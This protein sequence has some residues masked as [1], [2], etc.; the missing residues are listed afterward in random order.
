M[1]IQVKSLYRVASSD[2]SHS[3]LSDKTKEPHTHEARELILG[4]VASILARQFISFSFKPLTEKVAKNIEDF[5]LIVTF[6]KDGLSKAIYAPFE[7]IVKSYKEVPGQQF[8]GS[9]INANTL[10]FNLTSDGMTEN[11]LTEFSN[12]FKPGSIG[13]LILSEHHNRKILARVSQPPQLEMTPYEKK[14]VQKIAGEEF[15]FSTTEY[16]G[17][18]T[19]NFTMD[20]PYWESIE[21]IITEYYNIV[22]E[23]I[24]KIDE[25]GES[26]T[27]EIQKKVPIKEN[28]KLIYED[29]IPTLDQLLKASFN[30]NFIVSEAKMVL[31]G[32]GTAKAAARVGSAQVDSGIVGKEGIYEYENQYENT[33]LVSMATGNSITLNKDE[34][35]L[36]YYAGTAPSYPIITFSLT[37]EDNSY[38]N[39]GYLKIIG[40]KYFTNKYDTITLGKQEEGVYTQEK[41]TMNFTLPGFLESYNDTVKILK[42]EKSNSYEDLLNDIREN[43]TDSIMRS[44]AVQAIQASRDDGSG[45]IAIAYD[46][47]N[48]SKTI[49]NTLKTKINTTY[50][51]TIDC[52]SGKTTVKF[53]IGDNT[54]VQNCGDMMA[55]RYLKIEGRSQFDENGD[56]DCNSLLMLQSTLTLNDF[57]IDYKYMYL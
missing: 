30:E 50:T 55:S 39:D 45:N 17:N 54:Y 23:E 10:A 21:N 2:A 16:K 40:N 36:L 51:F 53:D 15:E 57:S 44:L 27:E 1:G 34:K 14:V 19:L 3:L 22:E 33:S 25:N 20:Y 43:I 46:K 12:W 47:E 9:T 7:D 4:N 28:L 8:Y 38:N 35:C 18:I 41:T 56:I 49:I 32:T 26:I 6:A 5:D 11:Q 37:V 29:G 31:Y 48:D 52:K 42:N 24:V 13:E